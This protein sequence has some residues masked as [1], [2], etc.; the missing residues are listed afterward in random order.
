MLVIWLINF[1]T[2]IELAHEGLEL[3]YFFPVLQLVIHDC[4]IDL[5]DI[6][7]FLGVDKPLG[8]FLIKFE[9]C[10]NKLF[11]KHFVVFNKGIKP[12]F[13]INGCIF[14]MPWVCY[15]FAKTTDNL[16]KCSEVGNVFTH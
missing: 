15:L 8:V 5:G 6:C 10:I 14:R 2:L 9:I 16:I 12:S 13:S 11:E 4:S 7:L 1:K 3:F